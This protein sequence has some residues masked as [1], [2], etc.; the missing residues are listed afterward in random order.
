MQRPDYP[1]AVLIGRDS[2]LGQVVDLVTA[3]GSCAL[4]GEAGIG[5][6][7]ILDALRAELGPR[8]LL[9]GAVQPLR[10]MPYLALQRAC[11]LALTGSRAEV[12][13]AATEAVAGQVLLIDD[14][15]WADPDTLELLPELA[16]ELPIVATI[17]TTDDWSDA[18]LSVAR[19]YG[20]VL[21]LEPLPDDEAR[22]LRA[23]RDADGH[24][25]RT[26]RARTHIG[27]EPAVVDVRADV[28]RHGR[29]GRTTRRPR[30]TRIRTGTARA[31]AARAARNTAAVRL[32]PGARAP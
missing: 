28:G 16:H 17:R 23:A 9:G 30:D 31:G 15:H 24:R 19:S 3:G 25:E 4:A 8:A 12:L 10:W 2:E 26:R 5:K 32:H 13:A 7:A 6:T 11:G 21:D 1:P 27:R 14:L 29:G 18:A 22:V 20:T